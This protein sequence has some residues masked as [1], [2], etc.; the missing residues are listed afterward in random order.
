[1]KKILFSLLAAGSILTASAQTLNPAIPRDPKIE[2]Q[3]ETLLK[4][5]T[6]EEKI[7]Q[8]TE[9]TIDI[10]AKRTNPFEGMN[11][12]NPKVDDLKKILK[13]Y[14]LEKKFDLS[15]GMPDKENMMRIYMAIMEIENK[16][17]FQIDEALLDSVISKYKVGSILNVPT[18]LRRQKRAGKLLSGK[19]RINQ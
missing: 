10:L 1:M 17:G 13:K 18:A 16:K 6:L 8:M 2:Q 11:Q 12:Q 9:L 4:K 3:I 15:K 5:M 7:G 19:Y 14:N